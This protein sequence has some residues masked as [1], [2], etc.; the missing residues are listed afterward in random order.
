MTL[1]AVAQAL[2]PH[3][4]T[5]LGAFHP[6]ADDEDLPGA[7]TLVLVGPLD[8]D[9]WPHVSAAPEFGDGG[10]DP[11]D[12]WSRRVIEAVASRT[13]A[14]AHFPFGGPPWQ[15][16]LSWA[17][18]SGWAWSSPVGLLVHARAGLWVSYRGALAFAD[19]LDLPAAPESPCGACAGQPCRSACPPGALG[20]GGYDVGGCRGFLAGDAGAGCLTLG[21]RVRAACPVGGDWGRSPAQSA[22]HMAAFLR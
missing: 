8:R 14:V 20:A 21:C 18:R 16:F 4:L 15:P 6:T 12:R 9:F 22:F 10:A 5:V 3:R 17:M 19:R 13:G 11:L 2:A 7:G 1:E